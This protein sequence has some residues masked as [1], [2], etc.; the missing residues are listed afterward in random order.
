MLISDKSI[1]LKERNHGYINMIK[2]AMMIMFRIRR[3]TEYSALNRQSKR[4]IDSL[5]LIEELRGCAP[6]IN[7]LRSRQGDL[8]EREI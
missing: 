4:T 8:K 6:A 3:E 1:V 2:F 7:L 5:M